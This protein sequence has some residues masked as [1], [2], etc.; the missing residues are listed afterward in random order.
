MSNKKEPERLES[1]NQLPASAMPVDLSLMGF[2]EQEATNESY[3]VLGVGGFDHESRGQRER[4]RVWFIVDEAFSKNVAQYFSIRRKLDNVCSIDKVMISDVSRIRAIQERK[5]AS[6]GDFRVGQNN[7]INQYFDDL[8]ARA[9][10]KKVSDIH[11]EVRMN[12][13]TRVRFRR[14]GLLVDEEPEAS[15]SFMDKVCRSIYDTQADN[16]GKAEAFREDEELSASIQRTIGDNAIKLRFQSLVAYPKGYDVILRILRL[17]PDERYTELGDLGYSAD[18][19]EQ[20]QEI[21]ARPIGALFITGVTGS[22]KSTTLKNIIM[23]LN[24][25]REYSYK[26]YTI[27]DPP[28][29]IIP[30]TTQVPVRQVDAGTSKE[31][32]PYLKPIKAAM[33]GDPDVI[34]V[35]E[36]RDHYTADSTKKATQSGHQVFSTLHA[37]SAM[38]SVERLRDLNIDASTLGSQDFLAGIVYQRLLP[39]LCP[40][41]SRL[42]SEELSSGSVSMDYI[43]LGKRLEE[44]LGKDGMS[45]VRI[46][47]PGC[48][49]CLNTG[50]TTRTVCAEIVQPDLTMLRLFRDGK[51]VEA[52]EYWRSMSDRDPLSDRMV[53]KTV[54]EHGLYKVAM[55]KVSPV[56]L[57]KLVARVNYATRQYA[58]LDQVQKEKQDDANPRSSRQPAWL[59]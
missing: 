12:G 48:D 50:I 33:R 14:N 15:S 42:F 34:M 23:W 36:I 53:G 51:M 3:V 25:Q 59:A 30:R 8:L 49:A 32:S 29:Y 28:E 45:N 7:K 22:G 19:E 47:G 18:Q 2:N 4:Q 1:F 41:C 26:I 57:E 43:K 10:K 38:S 24:A 20:I 44:A 56:D 11:I 6:S 39:L 40:K 21:V 31:E 46:K 16:E 54:L 9:M 5:E 17:D 37:P 52:Y 35:G 13:Y 27:E 58:E 55:G